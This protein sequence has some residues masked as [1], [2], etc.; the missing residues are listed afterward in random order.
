MKRL[1]LVHWILLSC[2]FVFAQQKYALV[3]G[4]TNYSGISPL[5]NPAKDAND[6]E[7]VLQE[8]GFT[9][10]KVLDGNLDRMQTA[11]T[12]LQ[13]RLR[14]STNS[15]GFFFYSGHGVQAG[16]DNY[17]IPVNANN[18][19]NESHL[20]QRA[21][22]VQT[23]LNNLEDAGN[24]LNMVVLDACRNNPFPWNRAGTKGLR[25]VSR[26]PRG[27]IIMY[28]AGANSV[29]IEGPPGGNG[30]F[31]GELIHNLKTPGISVPDLFNKT[32]I[33]V[34]IASKGAQ[35]PE[36]SISFPGM[37]PIYLDSRLSPASSPTPSAVSAAKEHFDRGVLFHN[38]GD[39][40]A[41]IL[42][43]T[44]AIRLNPNY[45]LAYRNRGLAY[46][47]KGDYDR[48]IMDYTQA[49]RINPNYIAAYNSRGIAYRN[50][51]DMTKANADF[52]KARELEL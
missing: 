6:M 13:R 18:I 33:D 48:A 44:Q 35:R 21:V 39:W 12:N 23:L 46:V 7:A 37:S 31:A 22:S 10:E 52:A 20:R 17:L 16:G 14:A 27:S 50:K 1:V 49:I 38:R 15:Y 29:S 30:L 32:E 19:L 47:G 41:A 8:L 51:G 40:D 43:Y 42:E 3:I 11:I 36:L 24:E 2:T 5:T 28:A 9:V 4:N 34:Y 26:A 25:A 45:D